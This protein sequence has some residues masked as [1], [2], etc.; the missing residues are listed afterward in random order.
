MYKQKIELTKGNEETFNLSESYL[1]SDLEVIIEVGES[2]LNKGI[3][4]NLSNST[5]HSVN[6]DVYLDKLRKSYDFSQNNFS[7]DTLIASAIVN[8]ITCFVT[9][10]RI[11]TI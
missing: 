8:D 3:T 1:L 9:L 4:L 2:Q 5:G 7:V 6:F 10:K 11:E